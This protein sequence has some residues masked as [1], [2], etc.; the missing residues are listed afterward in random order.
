VRG[1]S[2]WSPCWTHAPAGPHPRRRWV[3]PWVHP[4]VGRWRPRRGASHCCL[5]HLG[6]S[7]GALSW[8][9]TRRRLET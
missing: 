8:Q 9:W 7:A 4:R 3:H 1:G 5:H 6:L 2:A